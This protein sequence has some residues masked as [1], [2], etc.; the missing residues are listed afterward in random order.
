MNHSRKGTR[1]LEKGHFHTI[2]QGVGR[3]VSLG[4]SSCYRPALVPFLN[5]CIRHGELVNALLICALLILTYSVLG[6][7]E[8]SLMQKR[9]RFGL[10]FLHLDWGLRGFRFLTYFFIQ[11]FCF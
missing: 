1:G 8:F 7:Y 9:L 10:T 11:Q 3:N 6:P 2:L 4:L 5:T